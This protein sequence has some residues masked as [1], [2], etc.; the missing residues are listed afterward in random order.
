MHLLALDHG[1][2]LPLEL[3]LHL[4][5]GDAAKVFVAVFGL[6]GAAVFGLC[7]GRPALLPPHAADGVTRHLTVDVFTVK[8]YELKQLPLVQSIHK[9]T[10]SY[11]F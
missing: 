10:K 7:D 2:D 9:M 8:W 3:G 5:D 1:V 6:M 4:V 11:K